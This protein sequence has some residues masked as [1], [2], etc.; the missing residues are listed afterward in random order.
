LENQ[1]LNHKHGIKEYQIMRNSIPKLEK[2][3][4][5]FQKIVY[6]KISNHAST[7]GVTLLTQHRRFIC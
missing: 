7:F 2:S 1:K 4:Q 5:D 6:F 3:F